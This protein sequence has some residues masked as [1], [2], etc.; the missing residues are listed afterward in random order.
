MTD[1]L[2]VLVH[3]AWHSSVHWVATQRALTGLGVASAAVDLPG[4]G[5]DAP[6]PSGYLRAGQPGITTERSPLADISMRDNVDAVLS[7]LTQVRSRFRRVVLVGHSASGGVVSGVAEEAPE[8]LDH[9]IYL[10]AFVP[11]GRPRFFDYLESPENATAVGI[12]PVADPAI[13]G[14]FRINPLSDDPDVVATIHRSLLGSSSDDAPASP[15]TDGWR[16]LLQP[17]L[18]L[19]IP[20]TP[21]PVTAARWGSIARTFIRLTGDLALPVLTQDLMIQEADA[22][23]PDRRFAVRDL[24]GGHSPFVTRPAELATLLADIAAA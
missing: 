12:P 7:V 10:S 5:V 9:L 13:L 19:A 1:T 15:D 2:I 6:V 11:A 22:A 8:L 18:P 23:I 14:T 21:V 20:S 4:H 16:L 3:G 24:P 17:D